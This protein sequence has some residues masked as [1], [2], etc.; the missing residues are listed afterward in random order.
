MITLCKH[1]KAINTEGG[2]FG[3]KIRCNGMN[4]WAG[5][6]ALYVKTTALNGAKYL[7]VVVSSPGSPPGLHKTA[8]GI[9]ITCIRARNLSC[10]RLAQLGGTA[11]ALR[12][13]C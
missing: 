7:K 12:G 10:V 8:P 5:K 2:S 1:S 9:K 11:P 6:N 4:L 3:A 13:L